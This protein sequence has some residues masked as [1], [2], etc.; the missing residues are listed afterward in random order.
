MNELN[1]KSHLKAVANATKMVD[2][3]LNAYGEPKMTLDELRA[4]MD[5][6]LG[7]ESLS[8]LILRDRQ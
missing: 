4:A 1:S 6:E 7:G 8:E 3:A 5:R 2:R